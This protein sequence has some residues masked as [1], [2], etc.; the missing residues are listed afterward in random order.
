MLLCMSLWFSIFGAYLFP[1]VLSTTSQDCQEEVDKL[2]H[3][4]C[5]E[6]QPG[7]RSPKPVSSPT[8]TS[9]LKSGSDSVQNSVSSFSSHV[10]GRKRERVDKGQESVKRDRSTKIDDGGRRQIKRKKNRYDM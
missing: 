10:K 3:R 2:L 1:S 8:S 6:M 9:Q 4:T 5:V 7:G